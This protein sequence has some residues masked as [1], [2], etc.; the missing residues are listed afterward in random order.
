MVQPPPP[1]PSPQLHQQFL[2]T[3]LSQRG[4][5]SLPY[6]EDVKWLI[7]QHL[8]SLT[9]AYPSMTP[10]TAT[11]MHNDGRSVNLL[12]SDGTIPM[13]Y[14][15]VTYNIPVVIWLME[16]YP[17]YAPSVYV[18]P[19]R[20]MV[21]KRQ[22]PFVNP[23]GL[24][25]V[26]YLQNWVYP[27]SNLLD[28]C[29]NLSHYFGLDPPLYSN[30]RP[31]PSPSPSV[32]PNPSFNS[33]P[34]FSN[35]SVRP[36]IPPR[37][38]PPSPYGGGGRIS[39][40]LSSNSLSGSASVTATEDPAEVYRRNVIN[41]LVESV[42]GDV[43][44][45]RK[46]REVEMEGMLSAQNV[47]RIREEE[48]NKGLREMMDEKEGLEQ[49]LQ[50]VLMNMDV[51]EAWVKENEGKL[52]GGGVEGV[53]GDEVFEPA[54]GLSKQMLECTASDLAIEDVIYALDKSVQ[55]GAIPVDVYLRNVRLLSR[56]QFVHRATS[57]K[58][59]AAQM[60]AQVTS[61]ASRAPPY[62]V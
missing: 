8:I 17:R 37:S 14:Q 39:P 52:S 19:T 45:L 32:N 6:N 51:L 10:K 58:V 59:R 29:R 12:Q 9:E 27:S 56:E 20:D 31:N 24:V 43:E 30:R 2:S 42:H 60:Q 3:V 48:V 16:T 38:Y 4:P 21:I 7:R 50:M 44:E 25:V 41:K 13:V 55:E 1:P 35:A 23:N 28:L 34:S 53:S 5:S 26:S 15:N 33:N 62:A 18:N 47:L 57:M 54:D 11:F 61:M 22:H 36:A 49:Q 46:K 40:N